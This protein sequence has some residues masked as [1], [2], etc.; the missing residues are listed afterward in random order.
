MLGFLSS[1]LPALGFFGSLASWLLGSFPCHSGLRL[2]WLLGVV[3]LAF[4]C[5]LLPCGLL[6]L[7]SCAAV[8]IAAISSCSL[9]HVL[10]SSVFGQKSERLRVFLF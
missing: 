9:A 4:A 3:N 5:W 6:A 7:N 10:R 2:S 8:G 1:R